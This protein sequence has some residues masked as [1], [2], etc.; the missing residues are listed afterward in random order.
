MC[1][2]LWHNHEYS[3]PIVVALAVLVLSMILLL[4][5]SDSMCFKCSAVFSGTLLFSVVSVCFVAY[6]SR[7]CEHVLVVQAFRTGWKTL[8]EHNVLCYVERNKTDEL[9]WNV[10]QPKVR[11]IGKYTLVEG[12]H[13][14]GKST[15]FTKMVRQSG[16]HGA[17]ILYVNIPFTSHSDFGLYL[18]DVLSIDLNCLPPIRDPVSYIF[19]K[20][21]NPRECPDTVLRRVVACLQ[22]LTSTATKMGKNGTCLPTIIF[23]NVVQLLKSHENGVEIIT[24]L[25]DFA[26]H[27][28]DKQLLNVVF[29]ASE[30]NLKNILIKSSA[31]S[32]MLVVPFIDDI[33]EKKAK[34]YLRC[35]FEEQAIIIDEEMITQTVQLVGGRFNDLIFAAILLSTGSSVE[36]IKT[37]M[38]YRMQRQL[39]KL[40]IACDDELDNDNPKSVFTWSVAKK[41]LSNGDKIS[42]S[43]F[44]RISYST[45]LSQTD[46]SILLGENIF[47]R[48]QDGYITFQ[49]SVV[50]EYFKNSIHFKANDTEE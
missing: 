17:E 31:R 5:R 10:L 11:G 38:F 21:V 3:L 8:P 13:G 32:R 48:L 45:G 34:D 37:K 41:I 30:G 20:I 40:K 23:D 46:S 2:K 36:S 24:V 6:L 4:T 35:R 27:A 16:E 47:L 43:E 39:L 22:I 14:S 44:N 15:Y 25:Q 7:S 26:K 19:N 1:I 29:A 50:K 28:V 12:P 49:S 9:L 42:F 33:D 18:A